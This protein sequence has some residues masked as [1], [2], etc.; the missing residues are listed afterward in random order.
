LIR[1]HNSDR[2]SIGRRLRLFNLA[3]LANLWALAAV[4]NFIMYVDR[5]DRALCGDLSMMVYAKCSGTGIMER[6]LSEFMPPL[7]HTIP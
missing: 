7:N 1:R 2:L 4:L 6:S 5:V 3:S